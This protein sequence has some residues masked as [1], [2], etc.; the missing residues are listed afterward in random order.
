MT[1]I[2][3]TYQENGNFR[4]KQDSQNGTSLRK[5]PIFA[6]V[7]AI[8]KRCRERKNFTICDV[9]R[10]AGCRT[11][12]SAQ[13]DNWWD[14]YYI[15]FADRV[16][17]MSQYPLGIVHGMFFDRFSHDD[18]EEPFLSSLFVKLFPNYGL[19]IT[20]SVRTALSRLYSFPDKHM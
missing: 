10:G 18:V 5:R 4:A 7:S 20:I 9:K 6:M 14:K 8:A 3:H 16:S 12:T 2:I 15:N 11:R 17:I 13:E 19:I 1:K